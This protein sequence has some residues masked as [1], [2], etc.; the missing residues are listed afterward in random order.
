M[1][2]PTLELVGFQGSVEE[3]PI[4]QDIL[5]F[6]W[7][8]KSS[9]R[10]SI[11][12]HGSSVPAATGTRMWKGC[13]GGCHKWNRE[14]NV[15][16]GHHVWFIL[17]RLQIPSSREWKHSSSL[18]F[19]S[20]RVSFWTSIYSWK[21]KYKN[22]TFGNSLSRY[23]FYWEKNRLCNEFSFTSSS[24]SRKCI[25]IDQIRSTYC[26]RPYPVFTKSALIVKLSPWSFNE[27]IC[28][29]I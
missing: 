15:G 14:C 7:L 8:K 11:T 12:S 28:G 4:P 24:S 2:Y 3:I 22:P 1:N 19:S 26:C 13:N 9:T 16:S 18:A 10:H 23:T 25:A 20:K 5:W 17:G 21:E 27:Y 6:I 29:L